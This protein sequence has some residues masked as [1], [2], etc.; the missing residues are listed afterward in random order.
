[1]S[2]KGSIKEIID[3]LIYEAIETIRV[4]KHKISNEFSSVTA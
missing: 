3:E 2:L 4:N 1:M